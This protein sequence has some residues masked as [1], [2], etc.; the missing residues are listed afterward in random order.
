MIPVGFEAAESWSVIYRGAVYNNARK[1]AGVWW[2][3]HPISKAIL[4]FV[5]QEQVIPL[6]KNDV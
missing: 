1:I 3:C 5:V 6:Q 2:Y 4:R